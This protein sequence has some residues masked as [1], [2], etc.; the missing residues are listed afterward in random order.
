MANSDSTE[1]PTTED[2]LGRPSFCIL[3][4]PPDTGWWRS[5]SA[6]IFA[7]QAQANLIAQINPWDVPPEELETLMRALAS[8]LC[9]LTDE[10]ADRMDDGNEIE[11]VVRDYLTS[12]EY[13]AK[14]ERR[15]GG[16]S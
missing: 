5:S 12:D 10:L 13:T 7:L 8:P 16:E 11:H 3:I 2:K 15:S 6:L 1:T 4:D 14:I 9:L